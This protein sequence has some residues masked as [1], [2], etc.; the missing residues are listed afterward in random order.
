ML[1]YLSLNLVNLSYS[2]LTITKLINIVSLLSLIITQ[3]MANK[4]NLYYYL[5]ICLLYIPLAFWLM[6]S[7][8][9]EGI[10]FG[11]YTCPIDF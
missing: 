8:N 4:N 7:V 2:T 6:N 5:L 1:K 3:K 11:S 10:L 9:K